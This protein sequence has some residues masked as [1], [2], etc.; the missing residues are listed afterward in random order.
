MRAIHLDKIASVTLN[1]GIRPD[2]RIADTYPCQ[3][4][5]VIAVRILNSKS[6]YNTLELANGRMSTIKEGDIIAGALG[7]RNALQGYEG[8]IPTQLQTG[9]RINL[10]NLG[11]V[12]GVCNSYSALVG[13]PYQCEVLGNIL[14]FPVF[15]SRSGIPANIRAS[16]TTASTDFDLHGIPVV[17]VAGTCMNSGKTEACL[18]LIQQFVRGG[19]RVAAA[20]TTGVSLRRDILAMEDAGAFRTLI[21]T[22]FGVV[23]TQASNAPSLTKAMLHTLATDRPDLIVLE[24]GDGILGSYGVDAILEDA[25]LKDSLSAVVLAASDPVGAWGGVRLLRDRFAIDPKVVTGP[26]TDNGAGARVIEL[27]TGIACINARQSPTQL[28]DLILKSLELRYA[29]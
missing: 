9:D 13:P 18:A 10:L 23:T 26:A 24:L 11:G 6:K 16:V 27:E 4:G 20:K 8:S 2:A 3:E 5:D 7:H 17:A 22:D 15:E 25:N 19:M 28:A 29:H 1:C 12:L 14:D 21:F